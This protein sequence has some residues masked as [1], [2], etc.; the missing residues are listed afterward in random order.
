MKQ[1]KKKNNNKQK[2]RRGS[3][4]GANQVKPEARVGRDRGKTYS[5]VVFVVVAKEYINCC[6]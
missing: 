1:S 3:E 6:Y 2:G 4:R 5:V